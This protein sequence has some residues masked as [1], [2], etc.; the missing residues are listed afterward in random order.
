MSTVYHRSV[1]FLFT[2]LQ[3]QRHL[4]E[5]FHVEFDTILP[6]FLKL[7]VI[8]DV[9]SLKNKSFVETSGSLES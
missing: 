6:C 5:A 1:V 2:Q 8:L 4:P 9:F 3:E 7:T